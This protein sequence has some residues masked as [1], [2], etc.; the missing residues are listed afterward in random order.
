MDNNTEAPRR[1]LLADVI[2]DAIAIAK[3]QKPDDRS[4][5]ARRYA[6]LITELEKVQ[7]YHAYF[8]REV[9]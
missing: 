9:K 5:S 6:I 4:E 3:A 1:D 2:M 7:A 8:I